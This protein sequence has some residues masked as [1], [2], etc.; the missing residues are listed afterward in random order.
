MPVTGDLTADTAV[1][2]YIGT[3]IWKIREEFFFDFVKN[4]ESSSL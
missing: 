3:G 2:L 4:K 1:K